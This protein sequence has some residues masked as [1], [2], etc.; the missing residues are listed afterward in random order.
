MAKTLITRQWRIRLSTAL[1]CSAFGWQA[2]AAD[3]SD[4]SGYRTF[5]QI[6]TQLQAL[7][8]QHPERLQLQQIGKSAGG[9]PLYFLSI[10]AAGKVKPEQRPA[11]FVGANIAGFHHAG[12]EA[13]MHLITS[14]ANSSDKKITDLLA[15]R[16]LYI[17]PLLNPDAHA[18]LF[19]TPRQLRSRNAGKIDHDLDGL[20]AEDDTDDLD[21]NGI[22]TQMR[23]AD[24]TGDM[25]IDPK[26][27]RRMIKADASKGERGTHRVFT[28]GKDDDKDG[29]YN[30][31]G[32]G[33]II[34]DRNFAAG[35][36]VGD[37]DA[38]RWPSQAPETQAIMDALLARPNI[39]MAV[40]FGPANQLLSAPTGFERI[41]P[42]GA[43][44]AAEA[45][46]P[47]AD[48]L[49]I[50]TKLAD[51][52]KKSLEQKG[53]D[54]RRSA[55]QTGKGSF[56]NWLYFH[57][58]VQTIELDV[59][60]A[61]TAKA[62]SS[63]NA[64]ANT[65]TN[66]N[67][68]AATPN[69]ERDLLAYL[70]EHQASAIVAWKKIKLSDGTEVEVGG[71]DPFAEYAPSMKSLE[72]ALAVH[73]EQIMDWAG[74]LGQLTLV[75]AKIEAKG[76]DVWLVSAVGALQGE[77]PSHTKLAAR[78]RNKIP[79][80]LEMRTG[81]NVSSLTL[82][83]AVTT[84]RLDSSSTIKAEWLVKGSKGSTVDIALWSNQAGRVLRTMTLGE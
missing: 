1:V 9:K 58:G 37:T 7:A 60:G 11:L 31:D 10:A 77:F 39:A 47:E 73:G 40:V 70:S 36:P 62:A 81:K 26:D 5:E 46:K 43:T 65:N 6:E 74:K 23:I 57:Y 64:N 79:V 76:N 68:K 61:P 3:Q 49:K 42:P 53:L 75:E 2:N 33:G 13:A 80:R 51:P 22:I 8:K 56:A 25:I 72:P 69:P 28:E 66:A 20:I 82:N 30:E 35:F 44:P 12:S 19:Q 4:Y 45:N 14:L 71:I 59:W 83:R 29:L 34:P 78:M 18:A 32:V 54:S 55:R 48:D 84:E 52:Y 27:P 17:A 41:T 15:T 67:E 50:L 38:G 63:S 24:P 21:G 16:T